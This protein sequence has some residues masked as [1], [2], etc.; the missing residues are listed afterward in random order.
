MWRR[1]GYCRCSPMQ[2]D[3][4][5]GQPERCALCVF[6]RFFQYFL[7]SS[8]PPYNLCGSVICP[9]WEFSHGNFFRAGPLTTMG[10]TILV[11]QSFLT[12]NFFWTLFLVPL[13]PVQG[14]LLRKWYPQLL[15]GESG[16]G[17]NNACFVQSRIS[18]T[19]FRFWPKAYHPAYPR[20]FGT[21]FRDSFWSLFWGSLVHM[22][23]RVFFQNERVFVEGW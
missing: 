5:I 3:S 12:Y 17:G 22:K 2:P 6:P 13:P 14:P 19:C 16:V 20:I 21:Y 15:R 23:S 8:E 4:H 7:T 1:D 10:V 18:S 11:S 9:Y